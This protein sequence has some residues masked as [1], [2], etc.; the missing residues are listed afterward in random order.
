[1]SLDFTDNKLT[2]GPA[3]SNVDPVLY[4]AIQRH[5][6]TMFSECVSNAT[7][8]WQASFLSI[9]VDATESNGNT[10]HIIL[11]EELFSHFVPAVGNRRAIKTVVCCSAN[12][13]IFTKVFFI[14]GFY[15]YSKQSS[16][17]ILPAFYKR[18]GHG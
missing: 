10:Q 15:W 2:L 12:A 13:S 14:E 16:E 4:V 6:A 7:V 11:H 8:T 1:M 5:L 9:S 3:S 17:F 18:L